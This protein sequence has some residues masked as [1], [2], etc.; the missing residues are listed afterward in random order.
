M[1]MLKVFSEIRNYAV[2]SRIGLLLIFLI[3]FATAISI[4]YSY[5]LFKVHDSSLA[6]A[7]AAMSTGYER[8][9]RASVQTLASSLGEEVR[10]A[11]ER[12]EDP[13]EVLYQALNS[14]RYE[15]QGY[16]FIYDTKGVNIAHPYNPE[17]RGHERLGIVDSH[18]KPYIKLLADKAMH[19]GGFVTYYFFK[20]GENTPSPKLVYAQLIP[21]TDYWLATGLYIDEIEGELSRVTRSFNET[22]RN[23]ITTVGVGVV[24]TLLLI[25]L[26]TSLVMINSIL[27]PWRQLEKELRHAQKMEAIGIFASGISHD[28]NNILGAITSCSEL[29]LTDTPNDS[30]VKE[31]LQHILKAA[32]RGKSLINR[33]KAFSR[34][35]DSP[36]QTVQMKRIVRECMHLVQTFLPATITVQVTIRAEHAQVNGSPDQLL[37]VLMNLCTNAEQAMRGIKGVLGVELD[38][39]DLSKEEARSIALPPGCYVSL[40]VTD[41]GVGM[42]PV[43]LKHIFEPFYTTRKKTGGTGLGLSMSHSIVKAHGGTVTVKS[44]QGKGSTFRVF[45]PCAGQAEEQEHVEVLADLPR[46]HERLLIVDDDEDLVYS[47][48]KVFSRLGYDA[49]STVDSDEALALFRDAPESFDLLL[50]DQMMPHMTG[51][52]LVR[53]V[54]AIRSDLP[55][56]LCSGFEDRGLLPRIPKDL[57]KAGVSEFFSKPC[58]TSALCRAVRRLLD[59]RGG[60]AA[61]P[62]R[63]M[64]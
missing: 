60:A 51:T 9:L 55:V 13:K 3:L 19:G 27:K 38:V 34:R 36:R 17:F 58:D 45:L 22:H 49:V 12:G 31:D 33:I 64:T 41:N 63:T 1:N 62:P 44:A 47:L 8:T 11:R 59:A 26:P 48:R 18:G 4:T 23:A 29:A 54:H 25:V 35:A 42:K 24:L 2:V 61:E 50:T 40:A 5:Y 20:P 56:I 21:G 30:P 53:E 37:Q 57:K 7:K 16:Y 39:A 32:K 28:F 6:V 14:V 15:G 46:G 52:E 43:I 10:K